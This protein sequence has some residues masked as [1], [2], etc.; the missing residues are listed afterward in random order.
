M[1]VQHS[2]HKKAGN[3]T[4]PRPERE[5]GCFPRAT[6][7]TCFYQCS[8]YESMLLVG[9]CR[10]ADGLLVA[11]SFILYLF[12]AFFRVEIACDGSR[13]LLHQKRRKE[14]CKALPYNRIPGTLW[15]VHVGSPSLKTQ[16][17]PVCRSKQQQNTLFP[18]QDASYLVEVSGYPVVRCK[19]SLGSA[20]H[21]REGTWNSCHDNMVYTVQP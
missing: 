13:F 20:Q 17:W 8:L 10:M 2:V 1:C 18:S 12:G 16:H 11:Q 21:K 5:V 7:A 14:L 6:A 4:R 15:Q 3:D 19:L 9:S